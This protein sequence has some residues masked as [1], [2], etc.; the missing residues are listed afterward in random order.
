[1]F[2]TVM[3]SS[4]YSG[5][6]S[7]LV[8]KGDYASEAWAPVLELLSPSAPYQIFRAHGA[9]CSLGPDAATLRLISWTLSP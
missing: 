7:V 9:S 5:L 6:Q 4:I 2:A 8:P 3:L 1:M